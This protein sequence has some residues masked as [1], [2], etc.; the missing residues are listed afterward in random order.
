MSYWFLRAERATK[1]LKRAD[2]KLGAALHGAIYGPVPRRSFFGAW[3]T[4][5]E[6][7]AIVGLVLVIAGA[8]ILAAGLSR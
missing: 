7:L 5:K 3:Q 2:A 4:Y 8:W 6:V 1:R